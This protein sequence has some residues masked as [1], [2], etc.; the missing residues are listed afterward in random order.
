MRLRQ[1]WLVAAAVGIAA[2]A[3]ASA[4]AQAEVKVGYIDPD[5]ILTSYKPYQDAQKDYMSYESELERDY[6]K[7]E[8]ELKKMQE[9]YERKALLM[10]EQRK[11][12]EQRA[13]LK[14]QEELQR[15]LS[16]IGDPQRGKLA[17]KNQELSA[18]ILAKVNEVVQS[19]AKENGYDFV[20]NTTALA[21]ANEVHDLTEEVTK[22]LE[23]EL[24]AEQ[25]QQE[26]MKP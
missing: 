11:Q 9:D 26:Q 14:K 2:F 16:E 6:R 7:Q 21:Y 5:R 20:L 23:K 10:S 4:A 24:E 22:Q 25:E 17:R 8:N 12:E 18:P 19:V 13:I 3:L 15:F 1:S